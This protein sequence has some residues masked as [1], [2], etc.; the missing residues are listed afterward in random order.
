M[1][2][3]QPTQ[4][5]RQTNAIPLIPPATTRTPTK[6]HPPNESAPQ[7]PLSVWIAVLLSEKNPGG[8]NRRGAAK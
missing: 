6:G 1:P 4:T 3:R 2:Y 7:L 8:K 5:E